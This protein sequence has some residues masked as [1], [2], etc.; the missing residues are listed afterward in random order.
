M[1]NNAI[2][3]IKKICTQIKY[4]QLMVRIDFICVEVEKY[5]I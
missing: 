1:I 5:I 4:I 3:K 2:I